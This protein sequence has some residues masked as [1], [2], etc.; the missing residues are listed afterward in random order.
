MS[1][2]FFGFGDFGGKRASAFRNPEK[3]PRISLRD[4]SGSLIFRDICGEYALLLKFGIK[5]ED[6]IK[7]RKASII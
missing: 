4:S 1:V 5:S 3:S 2:P 6:F 7:V